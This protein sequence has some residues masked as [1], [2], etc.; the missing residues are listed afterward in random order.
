MLNHHEVTISAYADD[1]V[2]YLQDVKSLS[3]SIQIL[4]SF[5]LFSGLGINL[6]KS[7]SLALV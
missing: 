4:Q 2:V 6:E 5:H 1:P 7:E 3:K